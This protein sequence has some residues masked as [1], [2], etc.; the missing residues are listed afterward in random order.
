MR[1]NLKAAIEMRFG[2][3]MAFARASGLH[4]VKIS[5]L[6]RGWVEPTDLERVRISETLRAD[7]EWLFTVLRIPSPRC[8][9]P[10]GTTL[11]ANAV[12]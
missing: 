11:N 9:R 2:S 8:K 7:A 12:S 3:Q 4:P 6:C 5:R 1:A 10:V